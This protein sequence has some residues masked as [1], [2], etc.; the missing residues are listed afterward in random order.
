[1]K[2]GGWTSIEKIEEI[3]LR[4]KKREKLDEMATEGLSSFVNHSR[5]ANPSSK[6][7]FLRTERQRGVVI[8][9]HG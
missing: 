5:K 3:L 7:S 4:S 8:V 1:M 2:R 9:T 6:S